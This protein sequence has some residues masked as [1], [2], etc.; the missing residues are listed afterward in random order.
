MTTSM[1]PWRKPPR[2]DSVDDNSIQ[3][4]NYIIFEMTTADVENEAKRANE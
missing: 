1:E 3:M 4:S 2:N